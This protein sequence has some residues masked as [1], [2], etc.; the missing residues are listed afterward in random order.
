MSDMPATY[1]RMSSLRPITLRWALGPA[2]LCVVT[3]VGAGCGISPDQSPRAF[4]ADLTEPVRDTDNQPNNGNKPAAIFLSTGEGQLVPVNRDVRQVSVAGITRA[5]L[6][7]P[8]AA[9]VDAGV[10]TNIPRN[11][12]LLS[13]QVQSTSIVAIDLSEEFLQVD[14]AV[15]TSAVGQIVLGVG[16]Q[17][18]PS[19]R[20]TFA[21]DGERIT[22]STADGAQNIV[23][24]CDF[25]ATLPE[26]D[27]LDSEVASLV[28]EEA[29]ENQRAL[30][31]LSC[32]DPDE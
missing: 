12:T 31:D 22:I 3:L 13:G 20:F 1:T 25:A 5:T 26:F 6:A 16:S 7:N 11:T 23:A 2:L 8:T 32:A 9:E 10:T 19:R 29:L 28:D 30:L 14:G 27:K 17:Y 21:V 4:P 15:K 24:P 18:E